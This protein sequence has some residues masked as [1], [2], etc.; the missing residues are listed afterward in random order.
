MDTGHAGNPAVPVF[1]T[2][3]W[4]ALAVAL[5]QIV[6]QF[7]PQCAARQD[8]DC[9]V[10]GLMHD[11][12]G[13]IIRERAVERGGDLLGRLAVRQI[14]LHDR[15]QGCVRTKLRIAAGRVQKGLRTHVGEAAVIHLRRVIG[16][17][18]AGSIA[19]QFA[20]DC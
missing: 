6:S 16:T 10:D 17:V 14:V 11:G 2:R 4:P 9:R 12:L 1:S 15:E 18:C 3:A 8:I 7:T 20:T 19:R 13:W 5:T